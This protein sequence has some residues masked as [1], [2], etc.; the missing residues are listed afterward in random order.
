ML[1]PTDP[2]ALL[3]QAARLREV[4]RFHDSISVYERI[5]QQWP[6]LPDSWF[7]LAR[8]HRHVGNFDA[9]LKAYTQAL[10]IGIS[11]PEEVHLNRAVILSED[12]RREDEAEREL[13]AALAC[14]PNYA[15]ALLNLATL[16]EFRGQRDQALARYEQLLDTDP[17]CFEGLA[18]Y[19]SLKGV[20]TADDPLI[21]RLRNALS[22]TDIS[23]GGRASLSFSLGKLLDSCGAYDDA[24]AAYAAANAYSRQ[25][26]PFTGRMYNRTQH[27]RLVDDLIQVFDQARI[28][29]P[30]GVDTPPPP[31]FLCGMFRSGSTLA[32]QVLAGHSKVRAGGEIGFLPDLVRNQLQPYPAA[33]ARLS[34]AELGPIT[35]QYRAVLARL[36][37]GA[38]RVTDKRP[39]NY[40]HIGL[41]K[42]LF[43]DAR[44]VHTTRNPLDNAISVFFLNLDPSMPYALDLG[45]IG[46]HY[47][48]YRRLMA[49]WKSLYGGDILDFN[50]DELIAYPQQSTKRLL[51]FCGL[52]WEDGCLAFDRVI[53][54]VRTASVWQVRQPL[55]QHSSGRWQH[56]AAHL[57]PLRETLGSILE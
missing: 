33:V 12:L 51:D 47:R 54:A 35:L 25:S 13:M 50:Y 45:D 40:L 46:H 52:A 38:E 37:P 57:G 27:S 24:F 17:N 21:A 42:M 2:R 14:N 9:S 26:V 18:R 48:E 1:I 29:V 5:L 55:Y 6:A 22:Q 10:K 19:A 11:E 41:I 43:P 53:N 4:G 30:A 31:I 28:G 32:E 15:L 3:Q 36:A 49:H 20:S 39:D 23:A 16:H 8:L 7:N 34:P 44:I 56:Y